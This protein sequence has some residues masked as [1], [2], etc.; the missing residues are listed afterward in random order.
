MTLLL[1]DSDLERAS[2]LD[3]FLA[4]RGFEV[5]IA[6]SVA[7]ARRAAVVRPPDVVVV[8][9][10]GVGIDAALL[11]PALRLLLGEH[12]AL[13]AVGGAPCPAADA[14]LARASHP[15]EIAEGIRAAL[16]R[17]PPAQPAV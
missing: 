14:Q 11:V 7:E 10:E 1:V 12:P 6:A 4:A 5:Q 3:L 17:R 16:R 13:V 8:M 2:I 9:H 15:Q